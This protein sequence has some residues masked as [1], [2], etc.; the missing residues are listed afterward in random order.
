M[1]EPLKSGETPTS[2]RPS[3]RSLLKGAAAA[4]VAGWTMRFPAVHGAEAGTIRIGFVGALSGPGNLFGEPCDFVKKQVEKACAGGLAIGG[5]NYAVEVIVRDSQSSVNVAGQIAAELM[6]RQKVDLIVCPESYIAITGGQMAVIN[7]TPIIST[8]FPADAMVAIRGG[9]EAYSNKGKPW[10]FHFLFNTT[11][12]GACYMGMWRPYKDKLDTVGTLYCD[13]PAARGFADPNFGLPSFLN[14]EHYRIVDAG[15]FKNE[16]DDFT[17][18]ISLFKNANAEIVTGFVYSYQFA[19]FW[20][21][22]AQLGYKPEIVSTAGAFLFPGGL[23]A[24]GDRGDGMATE[25]WWTPKLPV[26]SSLTGQT[27]Q[28]LADDWEATQNRQWTPALGYTHAT[29]E[30]AIAALK[31]S[32]DPKNREAVRDALSKLTLDT[33]AGKVDFAGSPIPG[34]AHMSLAG[35][36]W[37]KSKGGKYKYDLVVTYNDSPAPFKVESEFKLLS[38]LA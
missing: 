32:G 6:T 18:Q 8:L 34:I 36:Q 20:R 23:D 31:A 15:L 28:A 26:T 11:D 38:Q 3:R 33:V 9:P 21:E 5:K 24:L 2:V 19:S 27:A 4:G 22:S 37:R 29:W 17:N 35:G 25:I 12:I 1:S 16:T 7:K 30:V 13:Q 14:K 10:T